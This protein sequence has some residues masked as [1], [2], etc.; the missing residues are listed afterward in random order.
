M[1]KIW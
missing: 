1:M